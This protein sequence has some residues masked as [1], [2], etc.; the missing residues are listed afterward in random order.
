MNK[1][2]CC[3]AV[4]IL[5]AGLPPSLGAVSSVRADAQP[6]LSK[7][8]TPDKAI[9]RIITR[10]HEEVE[11]KR[12]YLP[13]VET[14]RQRN[15]M[16]MNQI[17]NR[18]VSR[19]H[20]EI[21]AFRQFRPI[22]ETYIQNS[23]V[24][25]GEVRLTGDFY[26][27]GQANFMAD[28]LAVTPLVQRK[29]QRVMKGQFMGEYDP[30]GFLQEVYVDRDVFDR[31]YYDFHF[32]GPEFLGNVRCL[33]FDISPRRSRPGTAHFRGRIW[34]EDRDFTIVRFNGK[35]N[36]GG[37]H[38]WYGSAYARFDSWRVNVQP[39]LWLPAYI[40]SEE[41]PYK[42]SSKNSVG[43]EAQTRLWGY[44][45]NSSRYQGHDPSSSLS[46]EFRTPVQGGSASAQ[47]SYS[48]PP[49]QPNWRPDAETSALDA[50]ERTGRLAAPSDVDEA[51]NA[52]LNN[53]EVTNHIEIEPEVRCRV[54][55]T[56]SLEILTIG[57]TIALSRGLIDVLPD[58]TTLA[59]L[60]AQELASVMES[61]DVPDRYGFGNV[62]QVPAMKVPAINV[63]NHFQFHVPDQSVYGERALGIVRNSPYATNLG[64]A[65]TFFEQLH[66][67]SQQLPQLIRPRLANE[68]YRISQLLESATVP[69]S[70][71]PDKT[72]AFPMRDRVELDPWSDKAELL[73]TRHARLE[74]T[75]DG[76]PPF[77]IA[78][79]MPFLTRYGETA[80]LSEATSA[81][82]GAAR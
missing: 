59:I 23:K 19:E 15:D 48:S 70:D 78:P 1:T 68:V 42:G 33:V 44:N 50:L 47:H 43:F 24:R 34:A 31:D 4:S 12:S 7:A 76:S 60:L 56:T 65:R 37:R 80:G 64:S 10:E 28:G 25:S 73:K 35:F 38:I 9:D 3:L 8:V 61:N 26:L 77:K 29:G 21:I 17:I 41:M 49:A 11:T 52:V 71:Q 79:I 74:E 5:A 72:A 82:V 39:G 67:Q 62:A 14:Y 2:I 45:L 57:H 63:L 53:L 66:K 32:V 75:P 51:L 54:L 6:V 69:Q 18:I 30:R 27:L 16:S 81:P 46:V 40:F 36:P 13:I 58:E 55:T 22:I 20:D